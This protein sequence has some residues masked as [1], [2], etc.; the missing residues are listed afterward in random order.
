MLQAA[1]YTVYILGT[2]IYNILLICSKQHYT[3]YILGSLIYNILLICS[4]Q[5]DT[6][7]I[8]GTLNPIFR[9]LKTD[10]KNW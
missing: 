8:R 10:Y 1:L 3:V 9:T 6:V 2:L 4:K 5:H 7:Y